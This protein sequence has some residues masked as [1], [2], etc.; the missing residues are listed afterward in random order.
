MV[1]LSQERYEVLDEKVEEII[2]YLSN[3]E[4]LNKN[5]FQTDKFYELHQLLSLNFNIPQTSITKVMARILFSIGYSKKPNV[6]VGA[7]TYTGNALA[8]LSGYSI[9]GDAGQKTSI[10]GLDISKEA[11][12]ISQINFAN[13]HASDVHI[14]QADAISWITE[15]PEK[16]DLLYIDI[17]TKEDGKKK[18]LDLLH[19]AFPKMNENGLIIAHDI[20]EKKFEKDMK[21]FEEALLDETKFKSSINL[22]VDPFGL[23]I[24]IKR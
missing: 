20:N 23:S 17:D 24:S 10:Y 11:T 14:I 5:C 8:W 16:I 9:L 12:A 2:E 22:N 3:K 15:V 6:L 18:Y 19:V 13:I 4:I 1:N 21:P 7:G